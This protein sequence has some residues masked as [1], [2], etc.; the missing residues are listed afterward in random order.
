LRRCIVGLWF[1]RLL[2]EKAK[3]LL[4][5]GEVSALAGHCF[6][7]RCMPNWGI[8]ILGSPEANQV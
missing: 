4:D 8:V 5:T 6:L 1:V 7:G 3:Q 2:L